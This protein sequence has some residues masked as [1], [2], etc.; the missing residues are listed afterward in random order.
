MIINYVFQLVSSHK[1][2]TCSEFKT[3]KFKHTNPEFKDWIITR[4]DTIQI[5]KQ[6]F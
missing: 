4:N 2:I 1:K 5:K 3:G 6:D